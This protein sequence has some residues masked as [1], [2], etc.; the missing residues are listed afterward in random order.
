MVKVEERGGG[1]EERKETFLSLPL[2]PFSFFGS[3]FISRAAKTGLSLLRN[4]TETL[5]TQAI[6]VNTSI[7]VFLFFSKVSVFVH[8]QE[9]ISMR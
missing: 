6:S 9:S 7:S 8:F 5:A 2:P 3:R 4:Q 1:R